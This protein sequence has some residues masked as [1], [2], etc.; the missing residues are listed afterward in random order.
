LSAAGV[1][2]RTGAAYG[3][4]EAAMMGALWLDV[5]LPWK[6]Y[7]REIIPER[8][9][10]TVYDPYA[11]ATWAASVSAWHPAPQRLSR[12]MF[13]LHARNFGIQCH[14]VNVDLCVAFPNSTGG[15]GT[16][17]GMRIAEF[18]KIPLISI[19]AGQDFD[20]DQLHDQ[21]FEVLG[22]KEAA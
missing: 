7:N 19:R 18:L 15:G 6:S 3:I 8:A 10:I 13:A 1:R 2:I 21:V 4:D 17:Q 12:G 5:F 14:P 9:A 11:H 16:A 20:Y 22:Q